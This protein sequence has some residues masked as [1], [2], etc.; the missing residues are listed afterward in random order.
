LFSHDWWACQVVSGCGGRLIYDRE[1]RLRYRQHGKNAVG[2]ERGL[3]KPW[4]SLR[5]VLTG[6][7]RRNI[8]LQLA[9]LRK[10]ACAL[11]PENRSRLDTLIEL[12]RS[13]NIFQR[14][15]LFLRGGFYRQGRLDQAAAYL[16]VLLGKI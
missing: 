8:G 13:N 4:H 9:A 11:T 15:R 5:R 14:L 2:H 16:A 6:A 1:P 12:R 3:L 7:W 10:A